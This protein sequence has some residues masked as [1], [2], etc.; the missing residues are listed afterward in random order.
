M[1]TSN[2]TWNGLLFYID[3]L[4]QK[5]V[6]S[7]DKIEKVID[8]VDIKKVVKNN[9]LTEDFIKKHIVPRID[10][11]DYDGID[12]YDIEKYQ[13]TLKYLNNNENQE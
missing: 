13:S 5:G 4:I 8:L 2:Y 3:I 9:L 11:D 10:Y 12:L 6:L 7:E 1:D